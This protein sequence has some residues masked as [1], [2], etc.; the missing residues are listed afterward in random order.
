MTRT[1]PPR[2]LAPRVNRR[3]PWTVDAVFGRELKRSLKPGHILS[4]KSYTEP[5][6]FDT[7]DATV[8]TTGNG[9]IDARYAGRRDSGGLGTD[10]V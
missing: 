1:C 4:T 3:T 7:V 9:S 5:D 6:R 8:V 10:G 2:Q